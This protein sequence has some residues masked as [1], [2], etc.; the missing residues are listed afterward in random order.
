MDELVDRIRHA[1]DQT[2]EEHFLELLRWHRVVAGLPEPDWGTRGV[3]RIA[4]TE[5]GE[6]RAAE[7]LGDLR[8]LASH[9]RRYRNG[10][11][12]KPRYRDGT[13]NAQRHGAP[14]ERN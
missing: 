14:G 8:R 10:A 13:I 12:G 4:V 5:L 3:Y 9:P 1:A 2:G 7:L 11:D 6:D